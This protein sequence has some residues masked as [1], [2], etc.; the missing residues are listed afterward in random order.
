MATFKVS[1]APNVNNMEAFLAAVNKYG[2]G[3]AMA[4]RFLVVIKPVPAMFDNNVSMKAMPTELVYMCEQAE[5]P[6]K[7]LTVHDARY[8]G[9]NFKYPIQTTY[10]DITLNF[11][12]RDRMLEKEFFD[13]WMMSIN[14]THT[15]DFSYKSTYSTDITILQYSMLQGTFDTTD[16][17]TNSTYSITL[18]KAFPINV[19]PMQLIWGEEGFHRVSVTF[20]YNEWVRPNE[21]VRVG[22]DLVTVAGEGNSVEITSGSVLGGTP[23][24]PSSTIVT[25]VPMGNRL[26]VRK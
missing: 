15:Y 9:P 25:S 22:Y 18:K 24:N 17:N 23:L 2:A 5:L 11:M 19:A 16:R 6:G 8:Y 14:P 26:E 21:P 10:S 12:V 3:L 20:A 7:A 1:N 4:S 13:N